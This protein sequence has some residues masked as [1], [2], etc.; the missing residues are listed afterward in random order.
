MADLVLPSYTLADLAEAR[1]E[2][3]YAYRGPV[4][5]GG[6]GGRYTPPWYSCW[7]VD[8]GW[9][10]VHFD[11]GRHVRAYEGQWLL[12]PPYAVRQQDFSAN[13]QIISVAFH[14]RLPLGALADL[15]L[16]VVLSD[17]AHC[18]PLTAAALQLLADLHGHAGADPQ[19]RTSSELNMHTWFAIQRSLSHFCLLWMDRAFPLQNQPS[20]ADPRLTQAQTI[21]AHEAH[22]G[23]VPYDRLTASTGLGRVQLDRLFKQHV[24]H[25]PKA[26]RDQRCLERVLRR[27]ANPTLALKTIAHE[28]QFTDTSHLCRWFRQHTGRSP[29]Q[30]RRLTPI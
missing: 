11:D 20:T 21:L 30:H 15:Q 18:Q 8:R 10:E 24:G 28:L 4:P 26:E 17:A 25:S 22:M 5:Q 19:R 23:P 13:A 6:Q 29:E 16:P 12:C 14:P 7:M 27:L 2:L 1:L 3:R 9:A